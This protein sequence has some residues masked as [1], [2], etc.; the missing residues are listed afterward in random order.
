MPI[1]SNATK[2]VSK[3]WEKL[4]QVPLAP[5]PC[6]NEEQGSKRCAIPVGWWDNNRSGSVFFPEGYE[7]T[8][9]PYMLL[10]HGSGWTGSLMINIFKEYAIKYKFAIIAP[11]SHDRFYWKAPDTAQDKYSADFY[12]LQGCWDSVMMNKTVFPG[13]VA[14]PKFLTSFGNSFSSY[15]GTSFAS[16]SVTNFTSAAIIHGSALPQQMGPRV[17]PILWVTGS[18]DP[19]YGTKAATIDVANFRKEKPA[20]KVSWEIWKDGHSI[21]NYTQI[22]HMV[23]WWLDP[24]IRDDPIAL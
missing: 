20:Y 10:L 4:A 14:D 21:R 3:N 19:L 9:I 13:V 5:L 2:Y 12:H 7:N 8:A 11:D 16:R 15:A 6:V 18:L 17:F 22:E 1:P 23:N 24:S